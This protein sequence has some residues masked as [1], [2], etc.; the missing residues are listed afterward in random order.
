MASS[1]HQ[2]AL[3]CQ[4]SAFI[5]V[6]FSAT[7]QRNVAFSPIH[8]DLQL[9]HLVPQEPQRL[10]KNLCSQSAAL[11]SVHMVLTSIELTN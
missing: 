6:Q 5:I 11:Q 1:P 4:V 3:A 10:L 8:P 2:T 9:V 7:V